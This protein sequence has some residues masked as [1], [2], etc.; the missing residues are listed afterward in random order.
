[1]VIPESSR[2]DYRNKKGAA[3]EATAPRTLC[4]RIKVYYPIS[5]TC[6]TSQRIRVATIRCF[7]VSIPNG[8]HLGNTEI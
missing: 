5:T 3:T 6:P 7:G 2:R 8:F 4:F 1:M